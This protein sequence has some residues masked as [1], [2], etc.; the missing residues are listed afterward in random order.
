MDS[1]S[2]SEWQQILGYGTDCILDI[3]RILI[4]CA[5]IGI[6]FSPLWAIVLSVFWWKKVQ[7]KNRYLGVV[8]I[9]IAAVFIFFGGSFITDFLV[10][11]FKAIRDAPWSTSISKEPRN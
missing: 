1:S 8:V 7:G 2:S 5:E 3:L 11:Q 10:K 6:V 4:A 9:N